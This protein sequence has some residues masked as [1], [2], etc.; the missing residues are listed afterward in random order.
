[1]IVSRAVLAFFQSVINV[2]ILSLL[3]KVVPN[4][5]YS[6]LAL[7]LLHHAINVVIDKLGDHHVLALIL[8]H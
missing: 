8:I 7:N 4:L 5:K 3:T 2:V 6:F 1:M